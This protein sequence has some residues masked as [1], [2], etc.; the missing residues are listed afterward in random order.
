ML[1]YTYFFIKIYGVLVSKYMTIF[2]LF[3]VNFN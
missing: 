2:R 1:V 3:E